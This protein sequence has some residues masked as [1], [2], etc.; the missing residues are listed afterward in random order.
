MCSHAET[1]DKQVDAAKQ[2]EREQKLE[3]DI[4]EPAEKYREDEGKDLVV[5]DRGAED[6]DGHEAGAQQEQADIRAHDATAIEVT[7]RQAKP[8][9]REIIHCGRNQRQQHQGD[10]GQELGQDDLPVGQRFGEQHLD[11]AGAVLLSEA[12]HGDCRHKEKEDPWSEDKQAIEVGV[13]K[14]KQVEVGLKNPKKQPRNQ[15]EDHNDQDANQGAD[16][17]A[18]F[19]LIKCVHC[20]TAIKTAKIQFFLEL[21][22][23]KPIT[24]VSRIFE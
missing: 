8:I 11:G 4:D 13:A 19:F 15:Q 16:K 17:I 12:S 7:H 22:S 18:D 24:T 23:K 5:R 20:I 21:L 6:A 2:G 10:A 1:L 3:G 14:H 9:Y